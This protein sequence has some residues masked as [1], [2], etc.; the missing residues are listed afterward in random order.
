MSGDRRFIVAA[1]GR[2][3][4]TWT[5]HALTAA[6]VRTS[7]EVTFHPRV[8]RP[9]WAPDV[10]GEAAWEAVPFLDRYPDALVVHQVRHP[11]LV[12]RSTDDN[13]VFGPFPP[14]TGVRRAAVNARSAARQL[15]K[16]LR[17]PSPLEVTGG[18][19]LPDYAAFIERHCPAVA[20]EHDHLAKSTRWWL[21]WNRM[22]EPHADV[23]VRIEDLTPGSPAL[24]DL[25]ER[26]G[27]GDVD[28]IAEVSST[29][30]QRKVGEPLT[31][32]DLPDHLRDD[33][34]A[35]AERY[36]Y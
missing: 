18:A 17:R 21:E 7:H 4:T 16:R 10:R 19:I 29:T 23:R 6:G 26:V 9:V 36:G 8:R 25:L 35:M 27:G 34:R 31:W 32:D 30:N 11:L 13:H 15:A 12:I 3:G 24:A 2:S 1:V 5:A 28:A 14:L 20:A 33:V 22:T